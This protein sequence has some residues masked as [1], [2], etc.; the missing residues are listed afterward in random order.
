M[1]GLKEAA[2]NDGSINLDKKIKILPAY[3]YRCG[4]KNCYNPIED[5][6]GVCYF[7]ERYD[8]TFPMRNQNKT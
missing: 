8:K 3:G 4:V 5:S 1:K 7:V 6:S 2:K